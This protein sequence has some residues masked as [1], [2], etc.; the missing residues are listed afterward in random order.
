MESRKKCA[1]SHHDKLYTDFF[2][3]YYRNPSEF[4]FTEEEC[5]LLIALA[6]H[7]KLVSDAV[8]ENSG[9]NHFQYAAS[10]NEKLEAFSGSH[11]KH[12]I[13]AISAEIQES[14]KSRTHEFLDRLRKV[15]DTNVNRVEAGYRFDDDVKDFTAYI[16]MLAGRQA[17]ETLHRNL[18]LAIPSLSS[19][20]RYIRQTKE[21]L[22]EGQL[23]SKELLG[24]LQKR[25]LPLVVSL[26]EDATRIDSRPQYDSHCN[27][28]L[29]FVLPIDKHG[30]P[31]P[32]SFPARNAAEMFGHF[33]KQ[34]TAHFVNIIMAQ[35]MGNF[36]P[37][38]L[39]LFA[40][41]SKFTAKA[42]YNRWNFI[43]NELQKIG[44]S[45][46]TFSSDSDPRFAK[47]SISIEFKKKYMLS[48]VFRFNSAMRHCSGLGQT[49]ELYPDTGW[50]RCAAV[51]VDGIIAPF[52]VQDTEH[53][54]TKL[55]SLLLRTLVHQ[56]KLPFG[57]KFYIESQHLVT[58]L[59]NFS[60][61]QHRLTASI[62]DPKDK[63]NFDSVL[64]I[65]DERVSNLLEE[66]V[67]KSDAT[68]KYLEIIRNVIDAYNDVD[69][70]PLDRVDKIWH[71]VFVLR[72]WRQYIVSCPETTLKHNF[73]SQNCYVCIELN[74]HSLVLLMLYLKRNSMTKFFLPF[75]FNSQPCESYFRKIRSFTSTYSTVANCSIKEIIGRINKIQL[76]GDISYRSDYQYP[77]SDNASHEIENDYALPTEKDIIKRIE[78]SKMDAFTFAR[79]IGLTTTKNIADVDFSCPLSSL[80]PKDKKTPEVKT[81]QIPISD[82]VFYPKAIGLRSFCNKFRDKNIPEDS[83]Y[84][85]VHCK[86]M[87][88]CVIKKTSFCWL[89]RT[90]F[91][92]LSSDRMLRVQAE[93]RPLRQ[94]NIQKS[95]VKVKNFKILRCKRL[96][97]CK[98]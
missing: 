64:R 59:D 16:R 8:E 37:F 30:M 80:Q 54:G 55:K 63:M 78:Q 60:K 65:C 95:T 38:C 1:G 27:E 10:M 71:A 32:H 57:D 62:L 6:R 75:L 7:V 21:E 83:P 82:A 18:E 70:S 93:T 4:K 9:L 20:D 3:K 61:D 81:D 48:L 51:S 79:H 42:V 56:K 44:I 46:L 24:Y 89:L 58:L 72:L 96:Q 23:R 12:E 67:P 74:A 45:V 53:I 43:T 47:I 88:K 13:S 76:Q 36:A 90:D 66:N 73:L 40:S 14:R 41:D 49:S 92:K 87:E 86:K 5:D 98:Y 35:P 2:G 33:A 39:L 69:L 97:R 25:H 50:F 85:E 84:V 91:C 28:I 94:T 17:Y 77:R 11:F 19:V 29:G 22:I 34:K 26:S 68:R 52:Y 15:A 31:V